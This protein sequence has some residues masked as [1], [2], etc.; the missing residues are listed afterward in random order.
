MDNKVRRKT[1]NAMRK[2][3]GF[4]L[5]ELLIVIMIVGILS[6]LGFSQFTKMVEKSRVA[7]AKMILGNIRTAQRAYFLD[8]FTYSTEMTMV[9]QGAPESCINTHYFSY[10]ISSAGGADFTAVA[11]RCTDANGKFPPG[12]EA[13]T[14]SVNSTG[15]FDGSA[16]YY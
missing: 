15:T 12:T 4:T 16:G 7:E 14:V 3:K 5:L 10:A 6:G 8:N 13:Y 2:N 11:T 1:L 9:G